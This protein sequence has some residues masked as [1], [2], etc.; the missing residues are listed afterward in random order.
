RAYLEGFYYKPRIDLDLLREYSEGL[1][2]TTACL[3]GE[4]AFNFFTGQDDKA[5]EA[6]QKLKETFQDDFY[7]EIQRH[8]LEEEKVYDKIIDYAKAHDIKL[9]ATNDCHYMNREDAPAQEVLLCVQ[10]GKTFMDEKR[11]KLTTNEFYFKSPEEMRSQ[12]KDL[13]E[14]CDHTLEI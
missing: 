9:I 6:I 13:P 8:G 5:H 12:F 3:K 2:A 1:I 7:L 14:S 11:M 10:T 4:V